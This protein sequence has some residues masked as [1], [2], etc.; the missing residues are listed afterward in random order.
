[1]GKLSSAEM[2]QLVDQLANYICSLPNGRKLNLEKAVMA[3][4][5]EKYDRLDL[6]DC[7]LLR[8]VEKKVNRTDTIMDLTMSENVLGG[9]PYRM[10]FCVWQQR[11]Q[12][13]K[14]VS[15]LLVYGP[16]PKQGAPIKQVLTISSDGRIAFEEYGY[17]R[18]ADH[19]MKPGRKLQCT[20]EK[21][22]A[23]K[24]LLYMANFLQSEPDPIWVT[25]CGSWELTAYWTDG[26][27]EKVSGARWEPVSVGD[28]DL[29][30]L[31]RKEIPITGLAVFTS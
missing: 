20:I 1:M 13:V 17:N 21:E 27:E 14:I 3:V 30:K 19:G 2:E 25:D 10:D 15:D 29:S 23:E 12:K 4:C 16:E 6:L 24:I 18:Y 28:V 9:L 26:S 22:R 31:I 7:S 8:A 11:L 5:P